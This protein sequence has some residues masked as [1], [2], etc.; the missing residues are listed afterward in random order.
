MQNKPLIIGISGA[1]ASGKTLLVNTIVKELASERVGVISEDSYYKN[2]PHLSI[3]ERA[4]INYD[5]PDAFEHELLIQHLDELI[6]GKTVQIP[7]YDFTKHARAPGT[8]TMGTVSIIILEGIL[9]FADP[10]LR[11][12]MDIRIFMDTPPDICLVRRLRRDIRDRG[13]TVDSVLDQYLHTVRPMYF[14]FIEP[15]KLHADVIVPR[16]GENRIAIDMIK[17]KIREMLV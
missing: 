3:E 4:K 2:H 8:Q 9:I 5:H 11:E 12:R 6:A 17:T 16:G 15:S 7:T 10:E 14:Q 13:R 1:S